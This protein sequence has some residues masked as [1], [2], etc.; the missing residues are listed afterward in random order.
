MPPFDTIPHPFFAADL[1]ILKSWNLE[2]SFRV[3]GEWTRG[4]NGVDPNAQIAT[5]TRVVFFTVWLVP[6][7]F[8]ALGYLVGFS[9]LFLVRRGIVFDQRVAFVGYGCVDFSIVHS[10]PIGKS[11]KSNDQVMAQCQRPITFAP[12]V[13]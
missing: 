1:A 8:G 5:A 11:G 13:R 10:I 12:L 2:L 9:A 4:D 7:V 3:P 6:T